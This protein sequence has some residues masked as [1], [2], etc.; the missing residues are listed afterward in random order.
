MSLFVA[1]L[2]SGSNG[3]CYYISDGNS[4]VLIDVGISCREV[5]RRMK[6]LQLPLDQ[7][8]AIFITHEHSDHIRGVPVLSKKYDLPVFITPLTA[9]KC[10]GLIKELIRPFTAHQ[11]VQVGELTVIGFPK[12]HDAVD[13]H[14]FIVSNHQVT[15]GI[16]TDIG[17]VCEEV[18]KYFSQCHAAFLESN[19]DEVMLETGGYPRRLVNRIRGSKGHLSNLQALELFLREGTPHLTHLFLAHLSENNNSP[20]IVN[21]M[22]QRCAGE[23]LAVIASRYQETNVFEIKANY[24]V[25]LSKRKSLKRPMVKQLTLW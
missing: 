25:D 10:T 18:K 24:Q 14:S 6:R 3:N 23:T 5:E 17:Y 11:P 15:V 7:V 19:Y 4:A 2:N 13:P 21:N 22:F 12:W 16:F 9:Q 8:K 1:S 20:K